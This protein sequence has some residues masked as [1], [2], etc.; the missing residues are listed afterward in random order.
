[1]SCK[2]A[3]RR[4]MA[5]KRKRLD[6]KNGE[7]FS[8]R[9]RETEEY[10]RAKTVMLYMPINGEA[11]VTGLLGDDKIFL[12]PV[13]GESDIHASCMGE[14]TRG[15]FGVLEPVD[16]HAFDKNA[17]DLVLVPGVVFDKGFNRIGFGKGYY[18]RFLKDMDAVKIGICHSFQLVEEI[19]S[20][21]HD[22]KMDLI[23][24]EKKVWRKKT[25]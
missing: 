21:E 11:D 19:D 12:L 18:D 15:A 22:V 23:V 6:L 1:M 20:E 25:T 13:T 7:Q 17:I 2:D 9:I 10:K 24:T 3:L 16:K 8:E 14:L 4:E 5:E